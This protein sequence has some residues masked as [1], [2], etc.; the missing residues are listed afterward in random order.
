MLAAE[1]MSD[2]AIMAC[3]AITLP[4]ITLPVVDMLP[5]RLPL[6]T[7]LLAVILPAV[8]ID[9][10]VRKLAP[11]ILPAALTVPPV[12]KLPPE[13][14]PE[15]TGEEDTPNVTV[16]DPD[17]PTM[18]ILLPGVS[19]RT[20]VAEFATMLT[21]LAEMVEKLLLALPPTTPVSSAPLPI[22]YPAYTLSHC[23]VGEPRSYTR[24]TLGTT[25]ALA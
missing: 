1:V 3:V 12:K 20:P 14:L 16:F 17:E 15:K 22:K 25:V 18:V 9:P 7:T 19:V 6:N 11:V 5:T 23:L 24:F 10:V 13:T 2:A 21:P 8:E 4:A